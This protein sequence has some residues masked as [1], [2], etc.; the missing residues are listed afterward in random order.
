MKIYGEGFSSLFLPDIAFGQKFA[1]WRH[2]FERRK[3]LSKNV[4]GSRTSRKKEL[5]AINCN[6]NLIFGSCNERTIKKLAPLVAEI[7]SLESSVQQLSDEQLKAKTTEFGDRLASGSSLDDLLPEAFAVV[8]ESAVRNMQM[9]HY[10]V[11]LIGGVILHQGKIA[12][13][14]T[15]EGKTLTATLPAYLKPISHKIE[16]SI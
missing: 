11:Q 14:R 10:D 3:K 5:L 6:Y 1:L 8:R 7:N 15:G 4:I 16:R 13:M 12:E 2:S 9:R